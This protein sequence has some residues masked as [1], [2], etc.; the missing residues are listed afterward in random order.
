MR[1]LCI[2]Q[3]AH[4]KLKLIISQIIEHALHSSPLSEVPQVA[5]PHIVVLFNYL[6]V[7]DVLQVH[8]SRF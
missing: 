7:I 5:F 1:V 4:K 2:L 3:F 8:L 6:F